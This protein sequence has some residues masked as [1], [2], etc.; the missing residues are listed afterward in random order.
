ML[1]EKISKK[2]LIGLIVGVSVVVITGGL[3][4]A[5]VIKIDWGFLFYT[6]ANALIESAIQNTMESNAFKFQTQATVN[7]SG[8]VNV[9]TA[10]DSSS[11]P[12]TILNFALV[13]TGFLDQADKN[14][15]KQDI[16]A[17]AVLETGGTKMVGDAELRVFGEKTYLLINALPTIFGDLSSLKGQWIYLDKSLFQQNDSNQ[18]SGEQYQKLAQE[19][20]TLLKGQG[21]FGIK[22]TLDDED[23]KGQTAKHYLVYLNKQA[24]KRVAPNFFKLAAKYLP[25]TERKDYESNLTKLNQELPR[26]IEDFWKITGGINFDLWISNGKLVQ[27]KWE[28]ELD[29]SNLEELKNDVQQAKT[30]LNLS[31]V[32][33]DFG[34]KVLVE[35]P[36]GAKTLEELSASSTATNIKQ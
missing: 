6:K 22:K 21:L 18:L 20:V 32:Y 26:A 19:L 27:V 16:V 13:A 28:K 10:G 1:L 33:F 4:V 31:L 3:V 7:L 34:Q 36:V 9:A 30:N 35:K 2:Y 5:G 25:E 15:T 12:Q 29:L 24:V 8:I 23:V 11:A 14:N 17:Q